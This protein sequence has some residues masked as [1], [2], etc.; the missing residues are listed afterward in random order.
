MKA[1]KDL[2]IES[3]KNKGR[4]GSQGPSEF[5]RSKALKKYT[6]DT[7]QGKIYTN[8]S[9][10]ARRTPEEQISRAETGRSQQTTSQMRDIVTTNPKAD[11][12]LKKATSRRLSGQPEEPKVGGGKKPP[13][14]AV[15]RTRAKVDFRMQSPNVA[16]AQ[17]LSR[18][19]ADVSDP[20]QR[21][22]SRATV[23]ARTRAFSQSFGTP[24]GAD[25]RTG[26]A[27]YKPIPAM[28]ELPKGKG[29]GVPTK[30]AY[31]STRV[32]ELQQKRDARTTGPKGKPTDAG[33]KNFLMNRETKGA[34][35]GKNARQ[36]SPE[37]GK[38]AVARVNKLMTDPAEV[39][40]VKSQIKQEVG[41]RRMQSTS[42]TPTEVIANTQATKRIEAKKTAAPKSSPSAPGIKEPSAQV[43]TKT[44]V[45]PVDLNLKTPPKGGKISD[46]WKGSTTVPKVK[47]PKVAQPKV[48]DLGGVQRQTSI[49]KPG[50][51]LSVS[52]P[53]PVAPKPRTIAAP[54]APK[55]TKASVK[56]KVTAPKPVAPVAPKPTKAS[57]KPIVKGVAGSAAYRKPPSGLRTAGRAL[58]V[59]AAYTDF[60][61]G[62]DATLASGGGNKRAD[63][64]GAF[65]A[66][67]G[68]AGAAAG[69]KVG[70]VVAGPA[71][72][73]VGGT[74]GYLSGTDAGSKLFTRLTGKA[75]DKVNRDTV[76]KNVKSLYRE[77]VP[78]SIKKRVSPE[79][80]K[81][82]TSFYNTAVDATKKGYQWYKRFDKAK[83]KFFS[84]EDK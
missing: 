69:A 37:Q 39:S 4:P 16:G 51:P 3:K 18:A 32:G 47:A 49:P 62:R 80:K 77:K 34:L 67:S 1:F 83:D 24:T 13:E 17:D 25:W 46:P 61:S 70:A 5:E 26:K 28:T 50:A 64:A 35:G 36:I 78:T 54:V 63:A 56:P 20:K 73:L 55:P 2:V 68:L 82:F 45:K 21:A 23:R 59:Y 53:K 58:T 65:R 10:T 76:L 66:G 14:A 8:I 27:T 11:D 57:V 75:G 38:A 31:A 33:V 42:P 7:P 15:R 43:A 6:I 84:G 41:G 19:V 60:K 71:G 22:A 74:A 30:G 48:T 81:T 44:K 40:K 9:K 29:G 12:E 72:A 79:A 52:T